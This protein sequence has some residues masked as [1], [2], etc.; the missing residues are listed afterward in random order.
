MTQPD[1]DSVPQ[2]VLEAVQQLS[3][4]L[5]MRRGSV[6]ARY[7]KCSK[8]GYPCGEDPLARHGP[9]ASLT[10]TVVGRTRSRYLNPGTSGEGE[11]AGGSR[12]RVP[13]A[14]GDLL[15]SLRTLGGPRIRRRAEALEKRG[16]KRHSRKKSA[17]KWRP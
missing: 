6:S 17:K 4:P 14:A 15:A 8:P 13:A 12:S 9:Y 10:R 7:V 11:P 5:P 3:P 1:P 16:S 2:E